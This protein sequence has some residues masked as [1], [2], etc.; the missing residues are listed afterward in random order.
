MI[1]RNFSIKLEGILLVDMPQKLWIGRH[2][3]SLYLALYIFIL[4]PLFVSN[5]EVAVTDHPLNYSP[6]KIKA[7]LEKHKI[8]PDA[9]EIA[10]EKGILVKIYTLVYDCLL[11]GCLLCSWA[12]ESMYLCHTSRYAKSS[13]PI[14]NQISHQKNFIRF[15]IYGGEKYATKVMLWNNFFPKNTGLLAVK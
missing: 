3:G 9:L 13:Q 11:W 5:D 4:A 6:K 12:I 8:I 1:F 10:P 15:S 7:A 2:D 14:L